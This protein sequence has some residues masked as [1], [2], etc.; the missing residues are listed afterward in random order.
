MEH[1]FICRPDREVQRVVPI[2]GRFGVDLTLRNYM[3][4]RS[5]AAAAAARVPELQICSYAAREGK[6]CWDLGHSESIWWDRV[7]DVA[8]AVGLPVGF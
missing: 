5:L 7:D 2:L 3:R 4:D 1:V 6:R 8:V